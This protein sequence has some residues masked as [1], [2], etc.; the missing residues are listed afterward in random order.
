MK[1]TIFDNIYKDYFLKNS[2]KKQ[3]KKENKKKPIILQLTEDDLKLQINKESMDYLIALLENESEK[4]IK[5]K[6]RFEDA[7]TKIKQ[8]LNSSI[9]ENFRLLDYLKKVQKFNY[10]FVPVFVKNKL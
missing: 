10:V 9:Q 6:E 4:F 2:M 5:Y 8:S 1:M 3:N 7:P